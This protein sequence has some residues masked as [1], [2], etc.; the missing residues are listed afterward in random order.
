MEVK[1]TFQC[2][3]CTKVFTQKGT[4]NRHVNSIHKEW[5]SVCQ[6]CGEK[7]NSNFNLKRHMENCGQS[8][9]CDLCEKQYDT[10]IKLKLHKNWNHQKDKL[11]CTECNALF[12]NETNLKKH[13]VNCNVKCDICLTSISNKSNLKTHKKN[14]HEAK[15]ATF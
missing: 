14:A 6:K 7:F 9:Q 12:K 2:I 13:Q 11:P 15:S 4:L 3:E 1:S 5:F 10:R 8:Y